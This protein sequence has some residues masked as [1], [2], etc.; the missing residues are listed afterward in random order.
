M[1]PNRMAVAEA[2]T[3]P[4]MSMRLNRDTNSE[5]HAEN[6]DPL[7]MSAENDPRSFT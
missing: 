6:C 4:L 5:S 7:K 3:L 1:L 2:D